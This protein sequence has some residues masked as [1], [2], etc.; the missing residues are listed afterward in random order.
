MDPIRA[1]LQGLDLLKRVLPLS[2]LTTK[3]GISSLFVFMGTGQGTMTSEFLLR[4]EEKPGKMHFVTLNDCIEQFQTIELWNQNLD[5]A[6]RIQYENP[7]IYGQPNSWYT[8]HPTIREGDKYRK[9]SMLEKFQPFFS[10]EVQRSWEA[11]L[12]LL[13]NN[14]LSLSPTPQK[15]WE[16][17]LRWIVQSGLSGFGTGLAPLQFAKNIVLSGIAESPSPATMAQWIFANK[18]YGAFAGLRVLGFNLPEKASAAT[19]RAAFVCFYSWLDHHLSPDDKLVLHFDSIFVE[20]LL[21][22]IGRWKGRMWDMARIELVVEARRLFEG[23]QSESGANL[24]D[25]TKFPIPSC[26]SFPVSV[27]RSIIELG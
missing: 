14:D 15:S 19:V 16:D 26:K 2:L 23:S 7:A 6:S 17:V 9:L 3:T 20:Q 18:G 8:T 22:K 21:C 1:D 25:H 4:M 12:G 10:D 5:P 24:E 13:A 11:F 27:S